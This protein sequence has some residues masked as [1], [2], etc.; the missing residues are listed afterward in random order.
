M[1]NLPSIR[2]LQYL[3][4]LHE[5]GHFGRAAE[6]CFVSQST[7]SA[8]IQNLEDTLGCQLLEREHKKFM[9]TPIGEQIVAMAQDTVRSA[10][11]IRE[12]ALEY[13]N[14][15]AGDLTLG[16]IPTIAGFAAA[17]IY[18][19]AK[20]RY[21]KLLLTLK[22]DTSENL[23]RALY[24]GTVDAVLLAFPYDVSQFHRM[25]LARDAF[26]LVCH[27]DFGHYLSWPEL[28]TLPD[29]SIYLLEK[30]HCLTDHAVSACKLEDMGKLNPFSATS[31]HTLISMVE[32]QHGVTYLPQLAIASGALDGK[33]L[34][35]LKS[36]KQSASR[37]L[38]LIWRKSSGR[39]LTY[40]KLGELIRELLVARGLQAIGN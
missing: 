9:F 15:M 36:D 32:H 29:H 7:L 38:G 24:Q 39:V 3:L 14:P 35:C 37:D 6:A 26:Y 1:V 40:R 12:A 34:N 16:I 33:P 2:Q 21:P 25:D 4:T 17:E 28:Q 10:Q 23:V 22:E 30:E 20:S 13:K 5:I 8:A 19:L 11:A 31:L 18:A 27:Q